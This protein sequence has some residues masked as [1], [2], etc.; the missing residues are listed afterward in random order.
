MLLINKTL[1]SRY[2]KTHESYLDQL[3]ARIDIVREGLISNPL[4]IELETTINELTL[5][6]RRLIFS[7]NWIIPIPNNSWTLIR[8]F[9]LSL[10]EISASAR[11]NN[12]SLHFTAQRSVFHILGHIFNHPQYS[13]LCERRPFDDTGNIFDVIQIMYGEVERQ[14]YTPNLF[15]DLYAEGEWISY[16]MGFMVI[17]HRYPPNQNGLISALSLWESVISYS[18]ICN[19]SRIPKLFKNI[20]E[21]ATSNLYGYLSM[22]FLYPETDLVIAWEKKVS[23]IYPPRIKTL[24]HYEDAFKVLHGEKVEGDWASFNSSFGEA[25]NF[26]GVKLPDI[27]DVWCECI[28]GSVFDSIAYMYGV[29]AYRDLWKELRECW[30]LSQPDDANAQYC[31]H[32]F[33]TRDPNEFS[34]WIINHVVSIDR[35][36]EERHDLKV[37][38]A[39]ACTVLIGEMLDTGRSMSFQLTSIAYAEK[40][41]QFLLLLRTK[42][43]TISK[44]SVINAFGWSQKS[45]KIKLKVNQLLTRELANCKSYIADRLK[46]CVPNITINIRDINLNKEDRELVYEA[47]NQTN[48][49]FWGELVFK[50]SP[51]VKLSFSSDIPSENIKIKF[52]AHESYFLSGKSGKKIHGH[53]FDGHAVASKLNQI[54]LHTLT[55]MANSQASESIQDG[56]WLICRDD[57]NNDTFR[58]FQSKY[59]YDHYS[60]KSILIGGN[61]SFV[62]EK[63]AIELVLHEWTCM[64]WSS[65]EYPVVVYGFTEFSEFTTGESSLYYELKV[66]K[67]SGVYFL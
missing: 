13:V 11:N 52:T 26:S 3:K 21:A 41:E 50:A 24:K 54:L 40:L 55:A 10:N 43:N 5:E 45:N 33:F 32:P 44:Q 60:D 9:V 18:A 6:V 7:E 64:P 19:S 36:I 65:G 66:L 59:G 31:D 27:D 35:S 15:G 37:H 53:S 2:F 22:P 38:I 25:L 42:L 30:Y 57:W 23:E 1:I 16:I 61:R 4:D 28:Q 49:N 29:C 56:T 48:H 14:N 8:S 62:I 47:W 39:A 51:S 46:E 20:K 67:P 58:Q 12:R 34:Q 63:E 17:K